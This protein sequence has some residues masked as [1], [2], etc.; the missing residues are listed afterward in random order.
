M[1]NTAALKIM[2]AESVEVNDL[3]AFALPKLNTIQRPANVH[4][5]PAGSKALATQVASSIT[6]ALGGSLQPT[7][8]DSSKT[9]KWTPL[10]VLTDEFDGAKLDDAKWHDHNPK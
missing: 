8:K 10:N 3:Y 7:V 4:F 9:I 5:L 1:T 6:K 2:Q